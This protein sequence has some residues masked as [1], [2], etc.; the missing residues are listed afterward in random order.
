MSVIIEVGHSWYEIGR[1]DYL[2]SFFS[3]ISYY[4]EKGRWGK[5]YPVVMKKLYQ[6]ELSSKDA[7][8]AIKEFREIKEKLG[9]LE[10]SS[11]PIVWDA[12]DLSI[13]APRWAINPNEKVTT[14]ENYYVVTGGRDMIDTF[15]YALQKSIEI[16]EKVLI[17]RMPKEDVLYFDARK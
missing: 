11:N 7:D 5:K 9:S 13:E 17:K 6:G 10:K 15:I 14:L 8:L 4:L 3:T 2:H 16:E 1:S 12:Q